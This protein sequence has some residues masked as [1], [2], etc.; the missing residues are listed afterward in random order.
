MSGPPLGAQ[1]DVVPCPLCG[2]KFHQT[3]GP[4]TPDNRMPISGYCADCQATMPL[5]FLDPV[6]PE[7]PPE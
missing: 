4:P 2:G 1:K 5:T 3:V 6:D 7:A